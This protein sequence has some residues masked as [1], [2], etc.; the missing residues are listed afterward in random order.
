MHNMLGIG[1]SLRH[2][3]LGRG[4]RV[5]AGSDVEASPAR[6]I[7]SSEALVALAMTLRGSDRAHSSSSRPDIHRD[8]P[9]P[10]EK[11]QGDAA[12]GADGLG[13]AL[14][15]ECC[16]RG[17]EV[18]VVSLVV[19]QLQH[20]RRQAGHE[21]GQVEPEEEVWAMEHFEVTELGRQ[22]DPRHRE[23]DL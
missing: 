23:A 22:G 2:D 6:P 12:D 16:N 21:V 9:F 8:T 11:G 1:G 18:L 3:V 7:L 5:R 17:A 4:R 14:A 19:H 20:Q 10:V 13:A 15:D